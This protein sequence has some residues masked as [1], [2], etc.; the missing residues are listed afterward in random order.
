MN[1]S[2]IHLITAKTK[3]I[4]PEGEKD[5]SNF[6]CSLKR[7]SREETSAINSAYQRQTQIS[8]T[9][10]TCHYQSPQTIKNIKCPRFEEKN[11]H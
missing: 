5:E 3:I 9:G 10:Y 2:C 4:Q 7:I 11:T 6:L 1:S 8:V